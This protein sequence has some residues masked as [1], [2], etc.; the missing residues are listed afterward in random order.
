MNPLVTHTPYCPLQL[1]YTHTFPV[2]FLIAV[3]PF[4]A[5]LL[6]KQ[7][8]FPTPL[9]HTPFTYTPLFTPQSPPFPDLFTRHHAASLL[10]LFP[11]TQTNTTRRTSRK[12]K[13]ALPETTGMAPSA[14][15]NHRE[16]PAAKVARISHRTPTPA[17]TT[18][19]GTNNGGPSSNQ[20]R[21]AAQANRNNFQL[22]TR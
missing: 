21:M 6:G 4:P 12:T 9:F 14:T 20:C 5:H 3:V 2:L 16:T 17:E 19:G 22:G 10:T 7:F 8:T 15:T 13:C 1:R 18:Q 11:T